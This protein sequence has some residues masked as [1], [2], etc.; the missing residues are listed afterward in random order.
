MEHDEKRLY[1]FVN[2]ITV[3]GESGKYQLDA[4]QYVIV[5][6]QSDGA[7]ELNGT[8]GD[9]FGQRALDRIRDYQ[10]RGVTNQ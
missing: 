3:E 5:I 10:S 6:E 4:L 2:K 9:D 7:I 1:E 8:Y